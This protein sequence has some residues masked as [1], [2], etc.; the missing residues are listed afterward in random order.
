MAISLG[1]TGSIGTGKTATSLLFEDHGATIWSADAAVHRLYA[2]GGKAVAGVAGLVPEALVEGA[3]NRAFLARALRADQGLLPKLEAIVHPLVA[4]DR[5]L[6]LHHADTWLVVLEVPL[7]FEKG[8]DAE[9]DKTACTWVDPVEQRN[10][11]L[12]RPGMTEEQL[13]F[14]LK[15]HWPADQKQAAADFTIE[16]TSPDTARRDVAR[17]V[18]ELKP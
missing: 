10:R 11:V 8:I 18:K 15:H 13:T 6:A 12:R 3:I 4:E 17:I 14:I 9:V 1:L 7:L 16:T 5:E 2:P